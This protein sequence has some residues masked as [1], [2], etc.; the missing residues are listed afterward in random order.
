MERLIAQQVEDLA[1]DLVAMWEE[2]KVAEELAQLKR[3]WEKLT[4]QKRAIIV[5]ACPGGLASSSV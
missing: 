3:E 1:A 4:D 2:D 5:E